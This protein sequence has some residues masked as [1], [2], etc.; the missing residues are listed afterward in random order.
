MSKTLAAPLEAELDAIRRDPVESIGF[1]GKVYRPYEP[2][3]GEL[4]IGSDDPAVTERLLDEARGGGDRAYRLAVVHLLGMRATADVDSAL[5]MLLGDRDVG[6]T[7]AYLLGRMG[8]KGYPTRA[9]HRDSVI[10]ALRAHV[11]G[12]VTGTFEDPFYRKTFQALDFYIGALVRILGPETFS[13]SDSR[14]VEQIG[15]ALPWWTD[16]VRDDL[17]AQIRARP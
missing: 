3:T 5:V 1:G 6:P 15:Y 17:L 2:N 4:L 11:E 9:R 7:A 12:G 10:Q 16:D 14:M 13:S 8:F